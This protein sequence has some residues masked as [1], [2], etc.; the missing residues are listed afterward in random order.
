[1]TKRKI[2]KRPFELS[3]TTEAHMETKRSMIQHGASDTEF[4][5]NRNTLPNRLDGTGD[6]AISTESLKKSIFEI[7]SWD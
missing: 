7:S 2:T 3:E 4:T 5:D 1:M 6:N